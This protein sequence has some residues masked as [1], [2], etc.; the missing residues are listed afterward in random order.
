MIFP[1]DWHKL[2]LP[3]KIEKFIPWFTTI[4]KEECDF[5]EKILHWDDETRVAFSLAK[6]IFEENE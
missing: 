6:R 1:E 5:I 4:T 3:E 2:S